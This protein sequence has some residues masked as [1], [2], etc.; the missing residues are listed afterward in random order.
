MPDLLAS[1][2]VVV[3][4]VVFP[5]AAGQYVHHGWKDNLT[6]TSQR[7]NSGLQRGAAT[8]GVVMDRNFRRAVYSIIGGSSFSQYRTIGTC[9]C[10]LLCC[11]SSA[12]VS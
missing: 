8:E 6:D 4:V 7:S 1:I 10:G 11:F 9:N 12:K 2:V 3:V 5:N